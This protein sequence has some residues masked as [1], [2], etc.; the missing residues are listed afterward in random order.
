MTSAAKAL[1]SRNRYRPFREVKLKRIF[2]KPPSAP[3]TIHLSEVGNLAD[4]LMGVEHAARTLF[5]E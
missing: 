5:T 1:R 2:A 4:K 3:L